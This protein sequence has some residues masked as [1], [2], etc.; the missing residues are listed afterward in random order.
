MNIIFIIA[1]ILFLGPLFTG[2]STVRKEEE[3]LEPIYKCGGVKARIIRFQMGVGESALE[4]SIP[5]GYVHAGIQELSDLLN[6]YPTIEFSLLLFVFGGYNPNKS[7][8]PEDEACMIH[9]D[10]EMKFVSS[11]KVLSDGNPVYRNFAF[12]LVVEF[13]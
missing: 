5:S 11:E 4:E 6:Q 2:V 8:K 10:G 9:Y 12:A 3:I 7:L 13:Q 1:V